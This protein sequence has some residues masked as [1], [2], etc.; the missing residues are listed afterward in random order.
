VHGPGVVEGADG[1]NGIGR[2][3]PAGDRTVAPAVLTLCV[4]VG[5]VGTFN[6]PRSGEESNRGTHRGYVTRVDRN[7]D[8]GGSLSLPGLSIGVEISGGED[9]YVFGV[10]DRLCEAG[11]ELFRVFREEGEREGVDSEL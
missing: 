6:C 5:R 11:E 2:G 1:T 7:D 10:E 9:A 3:A 4:P 8:G